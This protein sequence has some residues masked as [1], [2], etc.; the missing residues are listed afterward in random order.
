MKIAL[1]YRSDN[2]KNLEISGKILNII[3]ETK[4]EIIK[5]ELKNKEELVKKISNSD[6][7]IVVGG[8]GTIMHVAKIC[9]QYN[10][11]IVSVNSG[12]LGFL[13]NLSES[14]LYKITNIL[15]ENFENLSI[16]ER[17]MFE[18]EIPEKLHNLQIFNEI[19]ISRDFKSHIVNFKLTQDYK[20]ICEYSADGIII[21]TPSGSTAYSLS[22][23][24]PV[25]DPQINCAIVTPICA[26]SLTARTFILD[27]QKEII[28]NYEL[29]SDS[30]VYISTDGY[31]SH[32]SLENSYVKIKK[33]NLSSKFIN[34]NNTNIYQKLNKIY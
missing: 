21:A 25:V 30:G 8:D 14:D 18:I 19:V 12:K 7:V 22:A 34:L 20:N 16:I 31:I 28:I 15:D 32:I 9:A 23:G 10:K 6:V 2:K 17:M 27:P 5:L 4:H 24:G 1:V 13:A 26:H 29:K 3:S 11:L 33:S